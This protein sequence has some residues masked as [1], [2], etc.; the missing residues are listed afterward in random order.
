MTQKTF[1]QLM[2]SQPSR[3]PCAH[4]VRTEES[5]WIMDGAVT[6]MGRCDVRGG[7]VYDRD[8]EDCAEWRCRE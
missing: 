6:I 2:A 5:G 8:C 7:T 1:D 3:G 4:L